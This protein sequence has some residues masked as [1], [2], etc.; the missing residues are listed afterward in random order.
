MHWKFATD[1]GIREIIE[2]YTFW[3]WPRELLE[4][5]GVESCWLT[6]KIELQIY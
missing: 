4:C 1:V 5:L 2:R 6:A 3:W